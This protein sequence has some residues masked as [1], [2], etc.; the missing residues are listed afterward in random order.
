ML[1]LLEA[2]DLFAALLLSESHFLLN[3]L[4]LPLQLLIFR[5]EVPDLALQPILLLN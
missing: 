1:F 5:F 2:M 3:H 4:V